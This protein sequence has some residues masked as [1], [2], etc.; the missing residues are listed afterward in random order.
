MICCMFLH[1][2]SISVRTLVF[3]WKQCGLWG[4]WNCRLQMQLSSL[5]QGG[6]ASIRHEKVHVRW[7][8]GNHKEELQRNTSSVKASCSKQ[9]M[10]RILDTASESHPQSETADTVNSHQF[11]SQTFCQGSSQQF[12]NPNVVRLIVIVEKLSHSMPV[13]VSECQTGHISD[14]SQSFTSQHGNLRP[15][16]VCQVGS[17]QLALN[18]LMGSTGWTVQNDAKSIKK[19]RKWCKTK[20]FKICCKRYQAACKIEESCVIALIHDA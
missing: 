4:E 13:Q 1:V 14:R 11:N 17:T 18:Q 16:R 2:S 8:N 15:Q 19:W 3:C 9:H 12:R 6:N 10:A 7:R 20:A 5:C